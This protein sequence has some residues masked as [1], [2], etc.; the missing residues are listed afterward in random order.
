[1]CFAAH[2]YVDKKVIPGRPNTSEQWE[3]RSSAVGTADVIKNTVVKEK[4][5]KIKDIQHF[6]T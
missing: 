3:K 5:V 2:N 4:Q 6:F 1:M